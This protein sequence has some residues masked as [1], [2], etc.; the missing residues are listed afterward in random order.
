[1]ICPYCKLGTLRSNGCSIKSVDIENVP[2]PRIPYSPPFYGEDFEKCHDC[3]AIEG[4][5]HHP[6]CDMEICPG[7]AGQLISC[8]CEITGALKGVQLPEEL[9]REVLKRNKIKKY[10]P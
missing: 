10:E 5:Y 9:I 4:R 1:M 7:C 3:G 6:G 8:D 2:R